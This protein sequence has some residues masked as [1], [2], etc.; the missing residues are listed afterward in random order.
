MCS[1]GLPATP[2]AKVPGLKKKKKAVGHCNPCDAA[3]ANQ[4]YAD[5][6]TAKLNVL[7]MSLKVTRE[8]QNCTEGE[9]V[10]QTDRQ[11]D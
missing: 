11:T 8:D 10:R 7:E 5:N 6:L 2:S 1:H 3:A 4:T 9:L